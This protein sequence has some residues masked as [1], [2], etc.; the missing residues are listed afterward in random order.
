MARPR[1]KVDLKQLETLASIGLSTQEMAAVLDCSKDTLE[2]RF[3][4]AIEKG[5]QKY[6][7]SLKRKQYEL[8]MKGNPTMLIWLGKQALGQTDKPAS[9]EG[10][11]ALKDATSLMRAR[12]KQIES[13]S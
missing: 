7:A 6:K 10:E 13:E 12:Y 8:A 2:R 1:K 5:R 9:T 4:K 11:T 3:M